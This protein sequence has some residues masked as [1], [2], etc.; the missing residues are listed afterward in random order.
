[1]K[2]RGRP[3]PAHET[4]KDKPDSSRAGLHRSPG[5]AHIPRR[6]Q[7]WTTRFRSP[8]WARGGRRCQP[9]PETSPPPPSAA[10]ATCRPKP[11]RPWR[12]SRPGSATKWAP[13][14]W[15]CAS[16]WPGGRLPDGASPPHGAH[17]LA[18][19]LA[20]LAAGARGRRPA[21]GAGGARLPARG[22]AGTHQPAAFSARGAGALRGHPV[23]SG[24][25]WAGFLPPQSHGTLRTHL[26]CKAPRQHRAPRGDEL[27][28]SGQKSACH[29]KCV[30]HGAE[31]CPCGTTTQGNGSLFPEDSLPGGAFR[32]KHFFSSWAQITFL[33]HVHISLLMDHYILHVLRAERHG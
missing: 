19:R 5:S 24:S 22:A 33:G 14:R 28:D 13:W 11:A 4:A 23:A 29:R 12:R 3:S 30:H 17:G 16:C 1:M 31:D 15:A 32:G 9:V 2:A 10:A 7:D 18:A 27:P 21:L 26:G 6:L 8:L 20:H 25:S